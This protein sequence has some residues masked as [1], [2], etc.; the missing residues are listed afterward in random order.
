M[1]CLVLTCYFI[2]ML[3]FIPLALFGG[4]HTPSP[5]D[6]HYN[7]EAPGP[8]VPA[9]EMPSGRW[10]WNL[11]LVSLILV[12]LPSGVIF[13]MYQLKMRSLRRQQLDTAATGFLNA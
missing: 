3:S 6:G 12:L 2:P 7:K 4:L 10:Y 1:L 11:P 9:K 13:V 8:N 5:W